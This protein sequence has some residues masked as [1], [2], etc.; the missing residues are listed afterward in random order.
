MQKWNTYN[1]DKATYG[2]LVPIWVE[3]PDRAES[4]GMLVNTNL[5]KGE[6]IS[7]GTPVAFDVA[8]KLAKILKIFKVSATSVVDTNTVITV[9]QVG[10]LPKL[11]TG[12]VIMVVPAT[13]AG[14]GKAVAT[15]TIDLSIDG[16]ATITV[17]TASIDAVTVGTY[18]AIAE[19][20]GSGK[21][22]YCQPTSLTIEDTIV[23]DKNSVGIA[24]GDK[25]VYQNTIPW[26]PTVIANNIKMLEFAKFNT[27]A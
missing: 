8:T 24:I 2:G 12:D 23:G 17:P 3:Q 14:T 9:P 4:G 26:L 27:G 10:N 21:A 11:N 25:Y 20:A 7:A 13:I 19:S 6:I 22:L 18:L 15:G 16:V 1:S 5:V